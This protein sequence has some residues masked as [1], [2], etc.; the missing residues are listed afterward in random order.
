MMEKIASLTKTG[1]A[2]YQFEEKLAHFKC[3]RCGEEFKKPLLVTV[4][5]TASAQ[6]YLA[7]PRCLT[8]MDIVKETRTETKR[9]EHPS[10]EER[11]GTKRESSNLKEAECTHFLGYLKKRPKN[12]PIPDDCLTCEKMIECLTL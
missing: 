8:K 2:Y 7:C 4:S 12:T 1:A 11:A 3:E 6:K 10:K 5:S 9:E